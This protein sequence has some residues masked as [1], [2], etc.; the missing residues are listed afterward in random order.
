MLAQLHLAYLIADPDEYLASYT[1]NEAGTAFRRIAGGCAGRPWP[2]IRFN[3][4]MIPRDEAFNA[5]KS[6]SEHGVHDDGHLSGCCLSRTGRVMSCWQPMSSRARQW[7]SL[8]NGHFDEWSLR[9]SITRPGTNVGL[10]DYG[11]NA[12]NWAGYA[13]VVGVRQNRWEIYG[14]DLG[15]SNIGPPVK[16]V[17]II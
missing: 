12:G 1:L 2:R 14:Q 7:P 13:M 4:R 5:A 8:E 3:V 10:G 16:V 9:R 11:T 6:V 17:R 15:L